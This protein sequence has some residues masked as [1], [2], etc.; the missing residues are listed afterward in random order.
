MLSVVVVLCLLLLCIWFIFVLSLALK[1]FK[2][3]PEIR[4]GSR[5]VWCGSQWVNSKSSVT[6]SVVL[7][8]TFSCCGWGVE[9]C[10]EGSSV[11]EY[12][13]CSGGGSERRLSA[14][15]VKTTKI[16]RK[17]TVKTKQSTVSKHQNN[18]A[19]RMGTNSV[20]RGYFLNF[21]LL[22]LAPLHL[23]RKKYSLQC[24]TAQPA[25]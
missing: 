22:Q 15:S 13:D 7:S 2:E 8:L 21:D 23:K 3:R 14:L 10:N 12:T 4:G 16:K 11:G 1:Y 17:R 19:C 5:T 9:V 18:L 24:N 6:T 25:V 20:C